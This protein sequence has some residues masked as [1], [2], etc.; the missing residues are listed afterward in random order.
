ML[1]N[2]FLSSAPA[3]TL[4]PKLFIR[5]EYLTNY[6]SSSC[7]RMIWC[8]NVRLSFSAE[9][10][11]ND[12]PVGLQTT[13]PGSTP[14]SPLNFSCGCIFALSHSSLTLYIFWKANRTILPRL[15][16]TM[17]GCFLLSCVLGPLK[18][19]RRFRRVKVNIV[20]ENVALWYK[21]LY[22]T[23]RENKWICAWKKLNSFCIFYAGLNSAICLGGTK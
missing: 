11:F 5:S 2:L 3:V 10:S 7:T 4:M 20:N 14:S 17:K 22:F 23:G 9:W 13:P 12:C 19:L 1:A 8:C 16:L 6:W 15:A 18:R 21:R